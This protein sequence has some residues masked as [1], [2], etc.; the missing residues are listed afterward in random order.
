MYIYIYIY[1][2]IH[3]YIYIYIC[4]HH[5]LFTDTGMNDRLSCTPSPPTNIEDFRGFDSSNVASC[6]R[7]DLWQ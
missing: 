7:W 6:A 1:I 2:N 5:M 3:V 4:I